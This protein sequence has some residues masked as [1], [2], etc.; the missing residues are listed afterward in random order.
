MIKKIEI[1]QNIKTGSEQH[2]MEAKLSLI[3]PLT[4]V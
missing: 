1:Y 3:W 4:V 2:N